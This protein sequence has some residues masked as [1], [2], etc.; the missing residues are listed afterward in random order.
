MAT[1]KQIVEWV[2]LAANG[3]NVTGSRG[4]LPILNEVQ[5]LILENQNAQNVVYDSS[6][7]LFPTF[8]TQ[9]GVMEYE[10]DSV[11]RITEVLIRYQDSSNY[12][13]QTWYGEYSEDDPRLEII[14]WQS[15]K[16]V[17]IRDCRTIEKTAEEDA[18]IIFANDPGDTSDYFYY[19]GYAPSN[20]ILSVSTQLSIPEKYH[21][22]YVVPAVIEFIKAFQTGGWK[23]AIKTVMKEYVIPVRMEMNRGHQGDP[24]TVT[25]RNF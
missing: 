10:I 6:T 1:T 21:L 20:Q 2:K 14:T 25:I 18:K 19:R 11:W 16:Y 13:L 7:G 15:K 12:E 23:E 24:D 3:W 5:N 8:D 22:P 9:D 17:K 4:I